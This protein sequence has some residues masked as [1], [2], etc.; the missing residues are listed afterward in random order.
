MLTTK[1]PLKDLAKDVATPA[2]MTAQSAAAPSPA[3]LPSPAPA[4]RMGFGISDTSTN[5]AEIA[6]DMMGRD[7]Q[8]MQRAQAR[9]LQ[10][11]NRRGLINSSISGQ[12]VEAAQMDA[13]LPVASQQAQL[14]QQRQLADRQVGID[15]RRGLES[16]V[17]SFQSLYQ[18]TVAN[19]MSN[20]DLGRQTRRNQ[21]EAAQKTLDKQIAMA[22]SLFGLEVDW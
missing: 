5:V 11:A 7:S 6:N 8:L 9:G 13:V 12:A 22:E 20:K 18:N 16:M 1:D 21:V 17:T 10:A 3:P 19:I 4:P 14:N 2:T 15:N